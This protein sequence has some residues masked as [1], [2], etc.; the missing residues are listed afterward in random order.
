MKIVQVI[1]GYKAG[2]GVGNVV[3]ALDE[4]LKKN[5]YE[6]TICNRELG[7]EDVESEL[8]GKETVV[9]YHFAFLMDPMVKYLECRKVL[10]FHNITSPELLEGVDEDKRLLL[11]AGWYDAAKTAGYF[12]MAITF[13]EYSKKCLI[14]M[15]WKAEKISVLPIIVRFNRFAGEPSKEIIKKYQGDSVNILFTGRISA[16]KKQED[17]IAAF[18]AYK[19]A[20]QKNARLFLVG[21]FDER[22]YQPSLL[23]YAERLGVADDVVFTGHVPFSEYLAYYHIADLFLCMSAHEGFCIP[24]AEAM[25]FGIPILAHASAAVP[26]TLGGSG[27][28]LHDRNFETVAGAMNKIMENHAYRQKIVEGQNARLKELLSETLEIRYDKVLKNMINELNMLSDR[29]VSK[30]KDDN[31]YRFTISHDLVRQIELITGRRGKY[32]VYGAGTAG[33][34]LYAK[35]KRNCGEEAL[36]LCDAHKAGDYYEDLDC[37]I[38]SPEEAVSSCAEDTF[39]VS[40]QDRGICFGVV[41]YLMEKGIKKSRILLYDKR[42]SSVTAIRG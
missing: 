12:D 11:S 31:K 27:V 9:L 40:I 32:V 1:D 5:Q 28:L 39:I 23:D 3:A 37:H 17:I 34:K 4:Y 36:T 41:L 35:L 14:D 15:G 22:N 21:S 7:C 2:D 33:A 13:S 19:Q 20:Y 38:I 16:N 8:F 26:D 18:S 10:V 30:I 29:S 42:L 6:T 25:Y 24:L